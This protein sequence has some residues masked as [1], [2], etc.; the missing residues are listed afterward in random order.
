VKAKVGPAKTTLS[1][2]LGNINVH[3]RDGAAILLH[4]QP[5]YTIEET[6]QGPYSLLVSQT[7]EGYAFGT[8]YID[9]GVSYPP[10]P[11]RTLVFQV[12]RGNVR[13]ESHG[14]FEVRQK[15]RE[16][17]VLGTTRPRKVSVGGGVVVGWSF[18]DARKKLVM[19]VELDLNEVVTTLEW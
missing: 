5:A 11:N 9:D 12:Q 13:I 10:G 16:V 19:E 7:A 6:R 8:A 17:V 18:F 3:I 1:A 4:L 14:S 2:P 15:L